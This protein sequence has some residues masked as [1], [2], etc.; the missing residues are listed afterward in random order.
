MERMITGTVGVSPVRL[1]HLGARAGDTHAGELAPK[2]GTDDHAS[3]PAVY[4]VDVKSDE[5]AVTGLVVTVAVLDPPS[6][7]GL[8]PHEET[9]SRAVRRRV[10]ALRNASVDQDPVMLTY[11]GRGRGVTRARAGARLLSATD[12]GSTLMTIS[13]VDAAAVDDVLRAV[14]GEQF[15]VAD[16]HHRLAAT[17]ELVRSTGPSS[18][19]GFLVDADDTPLSLGPI[20]RVVLDQHGRDLVRPDVAQ[21]VVRLLRASGA[22]V[23]PTLRQTTAPPASGDPAAPLLVIRHGADTW[24]ARW[25][26]GSTSDV[27]WAVE[28]VLAQLPSTRIRREPRRDAAELAASRGAV[29]LLLPVPDL[30]EVMAAA[31]LNLSLPYKTTLFRPKIPSGTL[32]RPVTRR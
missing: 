22:D 2:R 5:H 28:R 24:E 29:G 25:S 18:V 30:D 1:L 13:Q 4:V 19:T 23:S 6:S 8:F 11:R 32:V 27:A 15:L 14:G 3:E 12:S 17:T 26:T 7:G 16:G 9:D 20:H 10:R 31:R 21:E